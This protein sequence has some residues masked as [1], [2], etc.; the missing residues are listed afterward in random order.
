[1]IRFF[2][3]N[4]RVLEKMVIFSTA[5]INS[6]RS[7]QQEEDNQMQLHNIAQLLNFPRASSQAEID[8]F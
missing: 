7:T 2:L 6:A 8:I 4:A 1:M 3:E 5:I